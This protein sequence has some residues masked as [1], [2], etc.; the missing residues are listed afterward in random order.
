MIPIILES[1]TLKQHNSQRCSLLARRFKLVLF[2]RLVD[3]NDGLGGCAAFVGEVG[4]RGTACGVGIDGF[5][6]AGCEGCGPA[7]LAFVAVGE[8]SGEG[9][10]VEEEMEE[11]VIF[12]NVASSIY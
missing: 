5:E 6:S 10:V 7:G 3:R 2:K 4:A 11:R 1:T 9:E 12:Q 8:G